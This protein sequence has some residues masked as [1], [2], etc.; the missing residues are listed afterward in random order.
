MKKIIY[1][2]VI[3]SQL[4][5]LISCQKNNLPTEPSPFPEGEYSGSFAVTFKNYQNTKKSS[6]Q[7]GKISFVFYDSS[8]SY[9]GIVKNIEGKNVDFEIKDIGK[10]N[11][12]DGSINMSDD[13]WLRMTSRWLNS[14]YLAGTFSIKTKNNQYLIIQDNEFA[15]WEINL[16]KK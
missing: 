13:S 7:I 3:I 9:T 4:F 5:L 6:T 14:L 11:K 10:F 15:K 16:R 2:I 12:I 1:L 8:Y